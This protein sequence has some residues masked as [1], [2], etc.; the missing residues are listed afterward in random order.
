MLVLHSFI[1][2]PHLLL[3]LHTLCVLKQFLNP[4]CGH[5][6]QENKSLSPEPGRWTAAASVFSEPACSFLRCC[7]LPSEGGL[8]ENTFVLPAHL[9][10]RSAVVAPTREKPRFNYPWL[11]SPCLLPPQL[12]VLLPALNPGCLEFLKPLEK[13]MEEWKRLR[14]RLSQGR[15][16]QLEILY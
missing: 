9:L 5:L 11:T 6:D 10:T 15:R 13:K 8:L 14:K 4:I 1:Y 3:M 12:L 16:P 7:F 2:T